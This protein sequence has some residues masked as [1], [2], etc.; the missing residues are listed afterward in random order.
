ME[1]QH[2]FRHRF[3]MFLCSCLVMTASILFSPDVTLR[4]RKVC[5]MC[6]II[7][8]FATAHNSHKPVKGLLILTGSYWGTKADSGSVNSPFKVDWGNNSSA[9]LALQGR[10]IEAVFTA[11]SAPQFLLQL[12]VN[13]IM[14]PLCRE[15]RTFYCF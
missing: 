14:V 10:T 13:K 3:A 4:N 8:A 5:S 12:T 2:W 11:S 1:L 6:S 7:K 9:Q 15:G